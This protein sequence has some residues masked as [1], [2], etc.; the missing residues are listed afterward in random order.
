VTPLPRSPW[1]LLALGCSLGS[2]TAFCVNL[3]WYRAPRPGS[4]NRRTGMVS[5]LIPARNEESSIVAAVES[6]L[7]STG[8]DLQ[9]VVLDDASVDRTGELVKSIAARD[10]RVT[11]HAAP[12]LPAGWNGKQNACAALAT[13]ATHEVLCFLDADVRLE[14]GALAALL[15]EL[16]A[17]GTDLVSGFPLEETGTWLEKLLIPLIHFVLLCYCPLPVLR[18]YPRRPSVAA[19]CGQIM[20]V[21]KEAYEASGGHGAIRETM[22]DGLLLPRLLREHGFATDLFDLTD[23]A[24]C[25]MYRSAGEVWRGLSKNAT[26]GMAAPKH[27]LPF[28]ATLFFGQVLPLFWLVVAAV[29]RRPLLW[30]ALAV[31]SGYLVRIVSAWR[32]R[33]SLLGALLHPPAVAVLL[34]LQW[35]ALISKLRGRQAIWKE[36]AY[37][38]G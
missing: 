28:S 11:L 24:R 13:F 14:P 23:L 12:P 34:I 17:G 37:D 10:G 21:R 31:A 4:P 30:P 6:V 18:R 27:I 22:H 3:W 25:R 32:F 1:L 15:A 19:G 36:R 33:Q 5:V 35:W 16:D 8:V 2:C 29:R 9:L 38:V 26:E 20:L 7:A